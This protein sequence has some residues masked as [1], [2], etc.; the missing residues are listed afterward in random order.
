VGSEARLG[1][2]GMGNGILHEWIPR[3]MVL[4]GWHAR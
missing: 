4:D 1:D 3:W 2:M